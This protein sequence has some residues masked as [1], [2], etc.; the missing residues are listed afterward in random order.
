MPSS[1]RIGVACQGTGERAAFS[2]WL[3]AA[4]VEPVLLIDA[5]LLK[6]DVSSLRLSAV[7]A[8][9]G[10]LTKEFIAGLRR[11]DGRLP[12]IAV[13]DPGDPAE[14]VLTK[15]EVSFYPRPLDQATLML[16]ASL[17]IAE[18]RPARRSLRR[19]VPR[20]PSKIDGT[21]AYLL[22]ISAEGLRV[23]VSS[24]AG[25][26][27]GPQFRVQVPF[28]TVGVTVRRVWVSG[29][30]NGD[31]RR[32]YCGAS[33]ISSDRRSLDAWEQMLSHSPEGTSGSAS[34]G[35]RTPRPTP[36]TVGP[37]RLFGRVAQMVADAPLVSGLSLPWRSRS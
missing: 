24:D 26:K 11:V 2:D 6:A 3:R 4:G 20:L 35:A 30:A 36:A 17:A 13:G 28:S 32:M 19:L 7:I 27:L 9:A 37:D 15:R 1:P 14:R 33:L 25:A 31:P 21:A 18:S 8:D 34:A 5:C 16:A 29:D 23:E 12:I 10:L 22:D